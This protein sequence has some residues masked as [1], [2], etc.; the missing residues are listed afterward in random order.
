M[1]ARFIMAGSDSAQISVIITIVEGGD[2]LIRCLDALVA[3]TPRVA[4]EVIVPYDHITQQVKELASDY[5]DFTFVDLGKTLDGRIPKNALE[6]HYFFDMRR[7]GALKFANGKLIAIL[8]DRGIPE[9]N[10]ASEMVALHQ[11][12][13]HAA[14]G[15]QVRNGINKARN[16]AAYICDFGRYQPPFTEKDPTYVSD[17]NIAYKRDAL[18]SI[19]PLWEKKYDEV[20]VNFGL[21]NA[22]L[23]LM[24][25]ELPVTVQMRAPMGIGKMMNERFHWG[26]NYG[27]ARSVRLTPLKRF[28]LGLASPIIPVLVYTRHLRR[29]LSKGRHVKEFLLA[30]PVLFLL[31][32]CWAAGECTGYYE[33]ASAIPTEQ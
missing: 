14:I 24:L 25:S 27:Q 4:M 1:G 28:V 8:E 20:K 26:R 23:G 31:L 12:H 5:P 21:H 16:W 15:G 32:T 17:T 19:K 9:P 30:S 29:Q 7:S 11:Q 6:T 13:P 2:S 33:G 10:W 22:G 18:E 3:Q